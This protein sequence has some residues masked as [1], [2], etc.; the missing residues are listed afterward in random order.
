MC[1][2]CVLLIANRPPELHNLKHKSAMMGLLCCCLLCS[3]G[4]CTS[5]VHVW[6]CGYMVPFSDQTVSAP[7]HAA[8]VL[9]LSCICVCISTV[10]QLHLLTTRRLLEH[11]IFWWMFDMKYQ[12]ICV[13]LAFFIDMCIMDIC[14]LSYIFVMLFI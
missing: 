8:D 10:I 5:V 1:D 12:Y 9:I 7:C 3:C 2:P 13:S 14:W 6:L 11:F 4:V